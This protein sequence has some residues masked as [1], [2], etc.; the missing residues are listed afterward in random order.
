MCACLQAAQLASAQAA[1]F[2][3]VQA[4]PAFSPIPVA[5]RAFAPQPLPV[6]PAFMAAMPVFA[7]PSPRVF[8]QPAS[9]AA[10]LAPLEAQED[11]DVDVDELLALCL[12]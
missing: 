7:S 3:P 10:G 4:L 9:P 6:Q 12:G 11:D 5:S 2:A 1:L 8:E